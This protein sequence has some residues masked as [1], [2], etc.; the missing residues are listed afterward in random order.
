MMSPIND[1][2]LDLCIQQLKDNLRDLDNEA[3]PWFY[4]KSGNPLQKRI[5]AEAL[6]QEFRQ[7]IEELEFFR[8][9]GFVANAEV[10]PYSGQRMSGR[11]MPDERIISK[12]SY[13]RIKK[14]PN[15]RW[16]PRTLRF[17]MDDNGEYFVSMLT[18][19]KNAE[20]KKDKSLSSPAHGASKLFKEGEYLMSSPYG[21]LALAKTRINDKLRDSQ[22]IQMEL[23]ST[24]K[25]PGGV[26]PMIARYFM[27]GYELK[28][29]GVTLSAEPKAK[30]G[31]V[32]I[33]FKKYLKKN[34]LSLEEKNRLAEEF[35]LA[36]HQMHTILGKAHLDLKPENLL[37]IIDSNG[38]SHLKIFDY[39]SERKIG[40]NNTK[41][42]TATYASPDT[43]GANASRSS[44][45]DYYLPYAK[46]SL[47]SLRS[48]TCHPFDLVPVVRVSDDMWSLGT[49][50]ME[51]YT[52]L[53]VNHNF[54]D[55]K[56]MFEH[57]PSDVSDLNAVRLWKMMPE[58]ISKVIFEKIFSMD[59]LVR[60]SFGPKELLEVY[61]IVNQ[62]I[63]VKNNGLFFKKEA[64]EEI[65]PENAGTLKAR[66]LLK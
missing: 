26:Q 12:G 13:V 37:I 24:E 60:D 5:K 10:S 27:S 57:G 50:L 34:D 43:F 36:L 22:E 65:E 45:K 61:K 28:F 52:N 14:D 55:F 53:N 62:K 21:P 35:V 23:K 8:A 51:L 11:I 32:G 4:E 38:R 49:I 64:P 44:L 66:R 48:T 19:S 7:A 20:N 25:F 15:M 58:K 16:I 47:G 17:S 63:M 39:G 3:S 46:I 42:T 1:P 6:K 56:T 30:E 2:K 18:N 41:L 9:H 54:S 31:T 40:S 29:G 59:P 33:E